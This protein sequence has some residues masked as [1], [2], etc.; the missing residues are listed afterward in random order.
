M[1]KELRLTGQFS[2]VAA[3]GSA[4][5]ILEWTEFHDVNSMSSTHREW[6]AGMKALTLRSGEHVNY[7]G[8]DEYEVVRRSLRLR[9][10][11]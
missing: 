3:D 1:A 11:K 6:Q 7:L 8:D 10:A 9:K 5:N 2:A 4:Y